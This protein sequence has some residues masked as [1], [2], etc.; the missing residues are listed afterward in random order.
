METAVRMDAA[1]LMEPA[2]E[3][4]MVAEQLADFPGLPVYGYPQK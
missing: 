1:L 2:G 3:L 4:P